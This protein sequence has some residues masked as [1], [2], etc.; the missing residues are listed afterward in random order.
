MTINDVLA[1]PENAA[2]L[3]ETILPDMAAGRSYGVSLG[4][5]PTKPD[6]AINRQRPDGPR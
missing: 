2:A 5:L 1:T 4:S 3:F 6:G